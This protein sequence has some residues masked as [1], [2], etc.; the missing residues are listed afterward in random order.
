MTDTTGESFN[1]KPD[2]AEGVG[3][4]LNQALRFVDEHGCKIAIKSLEATDGTKALFVVDGD[5]AAPIPDSAFDH[6]RAAP[7]Y[8]RGTAALL[9]LDSFIDHANRFKDDG[10]VV[11]ANNKR[12]HPSLIAVLDYHPEGSTSA[13][14]WGRHRG[15]FTFPL[16]DEWKAWHELDGKGM[17]M[18]VFARFLE[19]HIVDVLPTSMLTFNEEQERF[20]SLRG[21]MAKIAEPGKLM[22]IATGLRVYEEVETISA[23]ITQTGET[24]MAFENRQPGAASG[25]LSVPS[26]FAIGIP[27]FTNGEPYQVL[28][29]LRYRAIGNGKVAFFYELWRTDRVFDHAFD[30]AVTMVKEDTGLPVLLGSPE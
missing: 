10:S 26:M 15:Q 5:N 11:F 8:R 28:V 27:V 21:G 23:H 18:P 16:S 22:E 25:E 29:Q 14:R 6:N 13:P 1:P 2:T 19:D 4:V 9:D 30:E 24:K 17:E 12:D 20:V 3:E 7:R